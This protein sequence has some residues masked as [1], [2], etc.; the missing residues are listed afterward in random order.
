[1]TEDFSLAKY[2]RSQGGGEI[3]FNL[4][5]RDRLTVE[6]HCMFYHE[7]CEFSRH[8]SLFV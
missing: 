6:T 2:L 8:F 5:S 7:R 3:F 4:W 1:M